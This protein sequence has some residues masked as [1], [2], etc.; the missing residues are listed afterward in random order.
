MTRRTGV[1]VAAVGA[2]ML[3]PGY[4]VAGHGGYHTPCGD[5]SDENAPGSG[6]YAIYGGPDS[7]GVIGPPGYAEVN[8][9]DIN[10]RPPVPT[11]VHGGT[12]GNQAYA[13]ADGGRVCV[14]S[15]TAGVHQDVRR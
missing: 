8:F 9:T 1:A 10:D 11:G 5:E 15:Q 2:M 14:G 4:A 13:H 6:T 12:S 7:V 3:L